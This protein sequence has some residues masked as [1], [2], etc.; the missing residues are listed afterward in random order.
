MTRPKEIPLVCKS[1]P[2]SCFDCPYPDCILGT[3]IITNKAET[4][5][6]KCGTDKKHRNVYYKTGVS[7]TRIGGSA[8][9]YI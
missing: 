6:R 3:D 2:L 4:A 7:Y 1:R 9:G 8:F 5:F